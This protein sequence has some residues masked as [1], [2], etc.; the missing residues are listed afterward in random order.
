VVL[1]IIVVIRVI[2][3]IRAI[4]VFR[5]IRVFR[6]I[7]AIEVIRD[8]RV[9]HYFIP[10]AKLIRACMNKRDNNNVIRLI[11]IIRIS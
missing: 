10:Q 7:R 2:R 1:R 4:R 5:V 11:E 6:I 9:I 8:I 3:V